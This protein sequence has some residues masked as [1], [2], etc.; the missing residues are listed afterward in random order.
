MFLTTNQRLTN[1]LNCYLE[2]TAPYKYPGGGGFQICN[3]SLNTLYQENLIMKNW[4]TAGNENM[5]L[6]RYTG[7]K[8]TLYREENVDYLFQ[9]NRHWPMT[10]N[11]ITYMSTCPQVM[12]LSKHTIIVT[13][14]RNSRHKKPYKTIRIKPPVQLRN[15]WYFQKDICFQPLV[16]FFTT[17]C[18][19]DRMFLNSNSISTT[20]GFTT[21]DTNG[22][23]SH[24]FPMNR[25]RPYEPYNGTILFGT[26][27][28]AEQL[29]RV[30]IG[31]LTI[32]GDTYNN[33]EGTPFSQVTLTASGQ[34]TEF[35]QKMRKAYNTSGYWGNPFFSKYLHGDQRVFYSKVPFETLVTYYKTENTYLQNNHFGLY[36]QKL[37]EC[38]YNAFKDKGKGNILYLVKTD[39]GPHLDDWSPPAD[40]DIVTKDLPLWVSIWGY[41]DYQRK[42]NT[43][44]TVDLKSIL[45]FQSP[46]VQAHGIKYFV[47]ID[48]NFLN[49]QSP[50]DDHLI[51]SDYYG[52]HPK[53]RFQVQSV[54]KIGSSAPASAKLPEET[55]VEAH[56]KYQ[57]YFKV[58][59][60]PAPMSNL[61]DP[62]KQP[63][64][65][66]LDNPNNLLQT[67]SL[68]NPAQPFEYFLYNFDQ[69]R[70]Q[71]T[72]TAADRILSHKTPE[73]PLFSITEPSSYV[74]TTTKESETS[75]T[76]N[77]EEEET[78]LQ[79][80]ILLQRREQKLLRKRINQLLQRLT[81][82]E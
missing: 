51:P 24:N 35:Q 46:Y 34:E 15:R 81:Q 63:K 70:G 44:D 2:S 67:T 64:W 40:E 55:S 80:Q 5:P 6:I 54:N 79:T 75:D 60:Q 32:L 71:I 50:F 77:E 41:L 29:T 23:K 66:T 25:T 52:W 69:R 30:K 56:M 31:D 73:D 61:T 17:C 49:G 62:N 22:F 39:S 14:K 26:H 7:C 37:V 68:Q 47:P 58:G 59:G 45:V 28:G 65:Q 10:A 3:F 9:Y 8:I 42:C 43:T 19:L 12:L 1:N 13:C 27:N 82:L 74:P 76:S 16:Q 36:T 18:S 21:L 78:S 33:T 57:F 20:M 53:V 38:R 4:W 72:K 11:K 48:Y